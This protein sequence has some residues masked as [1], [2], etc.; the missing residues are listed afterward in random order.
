MDFFDIHT[1]NLLHPESGILSLT[2][3]N[4]PTEGNIV[5]AS[6]GIHPW[7][8][9]EDNASVQWGMLEKAVIHKTIK[10][11]GECGL[12]KLKG[13]SAALQEAVFRK[14]AALAEEHSLPLIIHCVK[15]FNELIRL[16]KEIRPLQPWIL[17]GFRG[18]GALAADCIRHG[19]YLSFGAEFQ[20]EALLNTPLEKLF[21]ETDESETPVRDIYLRIAQTRGMELDEL[22]ECVK[23]NV[24]KV[25]FKA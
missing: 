16:K 19:C 23:N 6:V 15:A 7:Y 12:D 17:H 20:E 8:L 2:P 24:M 25:F 22:N 9:T 21:I 11:I 13:P 3:D 1:H 5:H 18:K 4:L 14:E 10:A